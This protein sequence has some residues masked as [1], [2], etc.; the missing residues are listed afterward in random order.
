VVKVL[1]DPLVTFTTTPNKVTTYA[2]FMH[3][4]GAV[5]VKPASWKDMFFPEI[6]SLPGS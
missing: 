3:E 4:I 5:K 2:D 1:E 6:H